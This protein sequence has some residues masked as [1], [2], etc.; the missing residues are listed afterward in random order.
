[1]AMVSVLLLC[2]LGPGIIFGLWF[3]IRGHRKVDATSASAGFFTRLLWLPG[4]VL[5]WPVLTA[6]LVRRDAE[7]DA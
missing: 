2:Y 5:L 4:A 1:M 7:L 6:K 3:L